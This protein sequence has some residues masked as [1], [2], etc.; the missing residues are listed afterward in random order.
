MITAKSIDT[1][2]LET[3]Y[4]VSDYD[5]ASIISIDFRKCTFGEYIA[6]DRCLVCEAGK[7]ALKENGAD[8]CESCPLNAV[9]AGGS[10]IMVDEGFWR[11]S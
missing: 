6:N 3:A 4:N 7:F 2:K 8:E 9:C 10:S 5:M 1:D 11:S